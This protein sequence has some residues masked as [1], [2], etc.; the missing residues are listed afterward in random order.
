MKVY[1][2]SYLASKRKLTFYPHVALSTMVGAID[3]VIR[4]HMSNKS[5]VL[6]KANISPIYAVEGVHMPPR[7][8]YLASL[9]QILK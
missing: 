3:Y 8:G 7:L 5:A 1:R 9:R 2:T 4:C 6:H